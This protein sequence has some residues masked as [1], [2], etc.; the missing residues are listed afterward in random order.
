M[1]V[2]DRFEV[3]C[4]LSS[5]GK[6]NSTNQMHVPSPERR[7]L[8]KF[9]SNEQGWKISNQHRQ[10]TTSFGLY[11]WL[12][13]CLCTVAFH[14]FF[15]FCPLITESWTWKNLEDALFQYKLVLINKTKQNVF[16][17]LIIVFTDLFFWYW[18]MHSGLKICLSFFFSFLWAKLCLSI[19]KKKKRKWLDITVTCYSFFLE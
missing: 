3:S 16:S 4:E 15:L 1:E 5:L 13:I 11:C 17:V 18:S 2:W 10:R 6:H 8:K 12:F 9:Y 7:D 14:F 19:D